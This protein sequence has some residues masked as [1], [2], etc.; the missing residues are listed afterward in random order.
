MYPYSIS[1]TVMRNALRIYAYGYLPMLSKRKHGVHE[2]LFI[3]QNKN[4]IFADFS[5]QHI[6][7]V[8]HIQIFCIIISIR[9]LAAC[10][11][12]AH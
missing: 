3:E 12:Q 10:L 1:A 6:S 11:L 5:Y 7:Q 2:V 8:H 4:W 9:C